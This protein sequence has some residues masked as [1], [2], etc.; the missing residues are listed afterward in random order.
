MIS[1]NDTMPERQRSIRGGRWLTQVPHVNLLTQLFWPASQQ[2]RSA[3]VRWTGPTK[4]IIRFWAKCTNDSDKEVVHVAKR[5]AMSAV[6]TIAPYRPRTNDRELH[7]L[8]H[9]AR[10]I[11]R[12]C[13]RVR[14]VTWIALGSP[15]HFVRGLRRSLYRRRI[16][17]LLSPNHPKW[18]ASRDNDCHCEE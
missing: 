7:G 10:S 11:W 9:V 5:F 1:K 16:R 18:W 8:M 12:A 13:R 6:R 15:R 14:H 2:Y 3:Q 17:R 4:T